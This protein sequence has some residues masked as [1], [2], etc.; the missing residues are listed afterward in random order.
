MTLVKGINIFPKKK[1]T[2]SQKKLMKDI[3]VF[4]KPKKSVS[5]SL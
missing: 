5:V 3:R 1:K 2:K 4:L